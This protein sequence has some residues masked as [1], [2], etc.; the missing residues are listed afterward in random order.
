MV[1]R[2]LKGFAEHGW[3]KLGREQIA[4]TDASALKKF[5]EL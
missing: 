2:L 5:A 4:I 1:S 3:V